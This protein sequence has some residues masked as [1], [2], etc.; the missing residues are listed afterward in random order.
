MNAPK[1]PRQQKIVIPEIAIPLAKRTGLFIY[2]ALSALRCS[3][4]HELPRQRSQGVI[5]LAAHGIAFEVLIA[6]NTL[7]PEDFIR[8]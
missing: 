4:D 1:T 3:F 7:P 6:E 2:A 8:S 5:R